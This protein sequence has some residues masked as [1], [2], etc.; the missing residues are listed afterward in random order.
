MTITYKETEESKRLNNRVFAA[1]RCAWACSCLGMLE[2]GYK[3]RACNEELTEVSDSARSSD[4]EELREVRV[5]I[6]MSG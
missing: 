5:F 4:K 2:K 1:P 3:R 6:A